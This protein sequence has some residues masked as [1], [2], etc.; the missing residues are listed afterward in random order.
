MDI[1]PA[2]SH[3]S[4]EQNFL[5]KFTTKKHGW[6]YSEKQ[7]HFGSQLRTSYRLEGGHVNRG[8]NSIWLLPY[9]TVFE[10]I[11]V[12][13]GKGGASLFFSVMIN[14]SYKLRQR[15]I[16]FLKIHPRP[17]RRYFIMLKNFRRRWRKW[18]VWQGNKKHVRRAKYG[19]AHHR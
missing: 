16:L 4:K 13:F 10:H 12:R 9:P 2:K 7:N 18:A 11:F 8:P 3:T 17:T 5:Q 15:G 6:Q 14:Q 19:V 1:G